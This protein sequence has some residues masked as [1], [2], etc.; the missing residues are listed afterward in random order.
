MVKFL[1]LNVLMKKNRPLR[2]RCNCHLARAWFQAIMLLIPFFQQ[3]RAGTPQPQFTR[4]TI[5]DGLPS[6]SINALVRDQTG[7]LW[8]GTEAGLSRY[9]GY[10][11]VNYE[12]KAGDPFA[13]NANKIVS[14]AIDKQGALWV[15]TFDTLFTCRYRELTDDFI[16][17][18][19]NRVPAPV[20]SQLAKSASSSP[21]NNPPFINEFPVSHS[22]LTR[23]LIDHQQILWIGTNGYGLFKRNLALKPFRSFS[24][25]IA[26]NMAG[27][28][29]AALAEDFTNNLWV[30]TR[31]A[32][33]V[34]RSTTGAR[35]R[36]PH[37]FNKEVRALYC[38]KTG[39][40]W[41][42]TRGGLEYTDPGTEHMIRS[43]GSGLGSS[44]VYAIAGGRDGTI[45]FAT[46]KGIYRA[47]PGGN[48]FCML[49]VS[50]E[51]NRLKTIAI[52][53]Q[54]RIWTGSE[55]K[56]IRVYKESAGRLILL[57]T[58]ISSETDS[59]TLS[60]D[61]ITSLFIAADQQVW[62]GTSNG[63]N[64]YDPSSG[65]FTRFLTT[66]SGL[67]HNGIAAITDDDSGFLW[68]SHKKGLS[69]I[70]PTTRA[71][72]NFS[73][74]AG[75]QGSEFFE[76]SVYKSRSSR[77]IYFGGNNG[78]TAF[79]P[80][81]I[82]IS[83]AR[84]NI[85]LTGLQ[86][87]NSALSLSKEHNGHILL[88]KALRLTD[89]INL[90]RRDQSFSI[91]FAALDFT[92]P[93]AARYAYK[94]EGFDTDW[95]FTGAD[96]RTA[97]YTDI[98]PGDYRF[99]V[100][101]AGDYANIRVRTLVIRV[102]HAWWSS[103]W[104]TFI[105]AGII[106]CIAVLSYRYI[107]QHA[108]TRQRLELESQL[109]KQAVEVRES[110]IQKLQKSLL[111]STLADSA[112]DV[113]ETPDEKL[114]RK[115]IALIHTRMS[116]PELNGEEIGATVGLSRTQLYRK[117]KLL[118]GMPISDLVRHVRLEY[119]GT[120]LKDKKFNVSEVAYM[121]GFSDTGY[122][123]KSFKTHYGISPS[124]YVKDVSR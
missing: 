114:M 122:F 54:Q 7:F 104:A 70:D 106:V 52:D 59:T 23:I 113:P 124:E 24:P 36:A 119:A 43:T 11:F 83:P 8:I 71:F 2:S 53:Q 73:E 77:L 55:G 12:A 108:R 40:M 20:K 117:V 95:I 111:S 85:V 82:A 98:P 123:R 3:A 96:H 97:S 51:F 118:C 32:G 15:S 121:T 39:R 110:E 46:W 31:F 47:K 89:T 116:D 30:G 92:D 91:E 56:G 45:W 120:L 84:P 38:D 28:C 103:V 48:P 64:R 44:P 35:L 112:M 75:L 102:D 109:R 94:L 19:A 105:I 99:K 66:Q 79:N 50:A 41:V 29:V 68:V 93:G 101:L 17:I 49:P 78:Y 33:I 88:K 42:G 26:G 4:F 16:R 5:A 115:I 72:I 9:D 80:Q 60:D 37:L 67:P 21:V 62:I 57:H 14:I 90:P 58:F 69:R 6:N 65:K 107:R 87:M 22:M 76:G 86:V 81:R 100:K 27:N 61:R 10:R 34:I 25:D 18:P 63:L 1:H 74:S 13:L